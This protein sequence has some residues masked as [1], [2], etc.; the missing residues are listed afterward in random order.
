MHIYMH[1]NAVHVHKYAYNASATPGEMPRD[2]LHFID[3]TTHYI[4]DTDIEK[5]EN[6]EY[7]CRG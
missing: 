1:A 2:H 6:D 5:K 4:N 7:R 3:I